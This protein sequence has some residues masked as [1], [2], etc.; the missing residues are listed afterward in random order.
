MKIVLYIL[1]IAISVFGATNPYGNARIFENTPYVIVSNQK[2]IS[3]LYKQVALTKNNIK[4]KI[5]P[6]SIDAENVNIVNNMTFSYQTMGGNVKLY[7]IITTEE[8]YQSIFGF[9]PGKEIVCEVLTSD[10]HQVFLNIDQIFLYQEQ[11][12]DL[13]IVRC[14]P[15]SAEDTEIIRSSRDKSIVCLGSFYKQY[16]KYYQ[17]L[18]K[19][20]PQSIKDKYQE[21]ESKYISKADIPP[22]ETYQSELLAISGRMNQSNSVNI[23][24]VG[25]FSISGKSAKGFL[26]LLDTNGELIEIRNGYTQLFGIFDLNKDGIDEILAFWGSGY[27]GGVE[28]FG[29]NAEKFGKD[30]LESLHK[31]TTVWD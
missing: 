3:S 12:L 8:G 6:V 24:Y 26:A 31:L 15:I 30:K 25:V 5:D 27:G 19:S 22:Y 29:M 21:I 23:L 10:N 18:D 14:K 13:I 4:S 20:I 2:F 11:N 1:T 28:L 17:P 9:W 16:S 7:P